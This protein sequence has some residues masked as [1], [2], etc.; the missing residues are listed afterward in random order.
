MTKDTMIGMD[1]AKS[2]FHL[3]GASMTEQVKFR[4][5]MSRT[6]FWKFMAS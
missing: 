5:K 1:L 4:K 3:H 6:Q 2:V